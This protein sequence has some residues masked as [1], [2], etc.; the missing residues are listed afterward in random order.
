MNARFG[1][2]RYSFPSNGLALDVRIFCNDAFTSIGRR[3]DIVEANR[4]IVARSTDRNAG[5]E[6]PPMHWER[7]NTKDID[8][9]TKLRDETYPTKPTLLRRKKRF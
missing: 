4:S 1:V 5:G 7:Y 9:L 8:R 3:N 6:C 2:R